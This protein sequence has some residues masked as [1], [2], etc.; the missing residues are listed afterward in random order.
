MLF[1]NS[2]Q[3]RYA[4]TG[5]KE[6]IEAPIPPQAY[7]ILLFN[8]LVHFAGFSALARSFYFDIE[9][10]KDMKNCIRVTILKSTSAE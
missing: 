9:W 10:R 3:L 8:Q 4:L 5:V 2:R 7:W 6:G 1:L